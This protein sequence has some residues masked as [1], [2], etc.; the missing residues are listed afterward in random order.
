MTAKEL[1]AK[2]NEAKVALTACIGQRP[3]FMW[4]HLFRSQA[5]AQR[6]D[7]V[8]AAQD[9]QTAT[10]LQRGPQISSAEQYRIHAQSH[11]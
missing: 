1:K 10:E 11:F 9:L 4:A 6:G 2:L 7:L 3:Q 5:H 8:Q